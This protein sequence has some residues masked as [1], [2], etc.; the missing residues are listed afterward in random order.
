MGKLLCNWLLRDWVWGNY[1]RN[2]DDES[3]PSGKVLICC[4]GIRLKSRSQWPRGL[5]RGSAVAC[6]LGLR[7]R[8]PLGGWMSVCCERWVLSGRGLCDW[9]ITCREESYRVLCVWVW[10]W[11]LDNEEAQAHDG[12]LRYW[13]K[14][15]GEPKAN[16]GSRKTGIHNRIRKGNLQN[17]SLWWNIWFGEARIKDIGMGDVHICIS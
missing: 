8:I 14:K 2:T 3:K 17:K 10:S 16:H 1:A 11:S 6:S 4:N 15:P 12:E 7:I 5:R 13:K 9:L